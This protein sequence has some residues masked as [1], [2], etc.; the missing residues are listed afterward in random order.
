MKNRARLY[1]NHFHR[2]AAVV[3]TA[4]TV[5]AGSDEAVG[6]VGVDSAAAGRVEPGAAECN[7]L[8]SPRT[9]HQVC[10]LLHCCH[11]Q[12]PQDTQCAV[13]SDT[14]WCLKPVR[15]DDKSSPA[16]MM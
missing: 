7:F 14:V 8:L 11:L 2:P 10:L 13:L 3:G 1:K 6:D 16:A 12:Q 15:E 4:E 9:P 5:A